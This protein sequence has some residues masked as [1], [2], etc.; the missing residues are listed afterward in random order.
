MCRL[1]TRPLGRHYEST[2]QAHTSTLETKQVGVHTI[3]SR[4][5]AATSDQSVITLKYLPRREQVCQH[6]HTQIRWAQSISSLNAWTPVYV[7]CAWGVSGIRRPDIARGYHTHL[8]CLLL[9]R[10]IFH[11]SSSTSR[12][13]TVSCIFWILLKKSTPW[14]S[15]SSFQS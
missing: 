14:S 12:W 7:C 13:I 9:P 4:N 8:A 3:E 5:C 1:P 11:C 15:L 2:T 6:Y 10:V